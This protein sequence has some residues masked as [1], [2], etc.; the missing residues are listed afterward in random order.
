MTNFRDRRN[1][2]NTKA[3]NYLLNK[4][5]DEMIKQENEYR[6]ALKLTTCKQCYSFNGCDYCKH[7]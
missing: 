4:Y 2:L 5:R 6:N 7:L 1:M 3:M